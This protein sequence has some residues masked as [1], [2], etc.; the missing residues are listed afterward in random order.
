M[1]ITTATVEDQ[2]II[3]MGNFNKVCGD[4]PKMMAKIVSAGKLTD[5]H[6]HK[7]GHANIATYICGR[8][9]VNFCFVLPRIL[10][11][12]LCCGFEAF[13]ARKICDHQGQFIDL[14]MIGLFDRRLPT[15]VWYC[16][17]SLSIEIGTSIVRRPLP[18]CLLNGSSE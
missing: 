9:R 15:I 10:D 16:R 11:H 5:V 3:L 18:L 14:S 2:D 8:R 4:D 12:V 6:A 7:H 17:V 1:L 13:H